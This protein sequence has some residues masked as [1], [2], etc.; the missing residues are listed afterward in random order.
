MVYTPDKSTWSAAVITWWWTVAGSNEVA[1]QEEYNVI[2]KVK[3][4]SRREC[5]LGICIYGSLLD[6]HNKF[7][8]VFV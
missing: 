4:A 6:L 1:A 5:R 8:E 3:E 7:Y 2:E